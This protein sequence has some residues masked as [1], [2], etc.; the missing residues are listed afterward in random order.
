MR[1]FVCLLLI[2]L[3]SCVS[4]AGSEAD[5]ATADV[6]AVRMPEY[7]ETDPWNEI[8]PVA[9]GQHHYLLLCID[10]WES[11]PRPADAP[12]I[13]S[14][15]GRGR[16]LYGC[17]DGM[18][19]LTLDTAAHR[20]M[21]TSIIRDAIVLKP[22][23]TGESPSFD[24]GRI[25]YVYNDSGVDALCRLISEHLNIKLEKYILFN[26]SQI[27][28]IIDL[29]SLTVW[30]SNCPRT[31]SGTWRFLPFRSTPPQKPTVIF[32]RRGIPWICIMSQNPWFPW[33]SGFRRPPFRKA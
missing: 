31:K 10:R 3:V 25:N 6:P 28:D 12:S 17:T 7:I 1:R 9:P 2:L 11:V 18:V 27:Q 20:I 14:E 21:L 24:Y 32:P 13:A 22:G 33:I 15:T 30:T 23:R 8:D 5:W 26:F 29:P 16:D 4:A 19:I